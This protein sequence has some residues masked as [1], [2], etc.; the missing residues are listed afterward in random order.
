MKIKITDATNLQLD[1]LVAAIEGY[2]C[3]VAAGT[4]SFVKYIR[5]LHPLFGWADWSPTTDP[6]QGHPY[7]EREKIWLK[8]PFMTEGNVEAIHGSVGFPNQITAKGATALIAAMRCVAAY[9]Y[10]E[11]TNV[12]D[13]LCEE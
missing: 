7:I 3:K 11:E 8:F 13:E 10:G 4:F 12:P 6:A 5:A 1:W 2:E 9:K